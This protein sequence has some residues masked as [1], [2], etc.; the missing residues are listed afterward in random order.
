MNFIPAIGPFNIKV[1]GN[2][3]GYINKPIEF[4]I[5]NENVTIQ[6]ILILNPN[7]N[8]SS[9][10]ILDKQLEGHL[11]LEFLP[12]T[13]GIHEIRIFSDKKNRNLYNSFEFNI[14][15]SSKIS[16]KI[17]ENVILGKLYKLN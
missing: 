16:V 13:L 3:K 17:S 5:R 1:F 2:Q 9:C 7:G 8:S 14:Y 11:S 10:D 12:D 6:E 4:I 15:D